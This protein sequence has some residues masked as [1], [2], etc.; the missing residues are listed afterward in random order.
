MKYYSK[1]LIIW[2]SLV[3]AQAGPQRKQALI[4]RNQAV[5]AFLFAFRYGWR[6]AQTGQRKNLRDS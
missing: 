4:A 2:R 5:N 3:Q 6:L 1:R